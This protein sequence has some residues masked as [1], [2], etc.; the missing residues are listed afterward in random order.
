M[1]GS[2]IVFFWCVG[3]AVYGLQAVGMEGWQVHV[4]SESVWEL[5]RSA[6]SCRRC[7]DFFCQK[8]RID[9]L[10][11]GSNISTPVWGRFPF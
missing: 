6:V 10:G 1:I 9:Y 4:H 3:W 8:S 5:Y 11:G 7:M 2:R